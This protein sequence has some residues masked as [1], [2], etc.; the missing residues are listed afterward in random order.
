MDVVSELDPEIELPL[1]VTITGDTWNKLVSV[2]ID[3]SRFRGE[4]VSMSELFAEL[5]DSQ[6]NRIEEAAKK[7]TD[8]E[9]PRHTS[10]KII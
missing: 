6:F 2:Q 7:L 3:V 1:R 4:Y 10:G 9:N 8:G 5:V